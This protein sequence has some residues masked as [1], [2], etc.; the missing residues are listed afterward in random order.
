MTRRVI[1]PIALLALMGACTFDT[2]GVPIGTALPKMDRG[3]D[4]PDAAPDLPITPDLPLPDMPLDL[5]EIDGPKQDFPLDDLPPPDLPPLDMPL[6]D[7]PPPDMPL[8]DLP[9]ADAAKADMP[10]PDQWVD[11]PDLWPALDKPLPDMAKDQGIIFPDFWPAADA[12]P[13]PDL[14][15]PYDTA[16][17]KDLVPW[18]P[19]LYP[20]P[21]CAVLFQ[22]V[23]KNYKLCSEGVNTCR[24]FHNQDWGGAVSCTSLC[25]KKKCLGAWDTA[26]WDKCGTGSGTNCTKKLNTGTCNCGKW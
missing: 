2:S 21:S 16:P 4:L 15:S 22:P 3:T 23:A 20:L 17:G 14:V 13:W 9:V 26:T 10:Q 11:P 1:V 12:K 25:G 18:A 7:M 24:F 6:L 19:D 8:P 5:P